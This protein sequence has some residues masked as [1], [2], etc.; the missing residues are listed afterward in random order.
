LAAAASL[1]LAGCA[2]GS[3]PAAGN[4]RLRLAVSSQP[5]SLNP[6]FNDTLTVVQELNRLYDDPL[7]TYDAD[8]RLIPR[9]AAR[10][11]SI[12]NGDIS[13]D[14]RTIVVRLRHD[15]KWQDG[16]PFTS[17]DVRFSWQAMMDPKNNVGSRDGIDRILTIETPDPFTAVVHMRAAYARAVPYSFPPL[18][19]EHALRGADLNTSPFNAAPIGTGPFRVVAWKRGDYIDL[20]ANDAYYLGRPK[21]RTIRVNDVPAA[22]TRVIMLK[23]GEI[24]LAEL[25]AEGYRQV[26]NAPNVKV[27][28]YPSRSTFEFFLNVT[29][30]NL[31][32]VRVRRAIA[33]ALD[34][35]AL[36]R[37]SSYDGYPDTLANGY[38]DPGS[39]AYDPGLAPVPYDP[40]Q[41]ARLL[42][43]AGWHLASDGFRWKDGRRLTLQLVTRS[44]ASGE[45][46]TNT[47]AQAMLHAAGI[48]AQLKA[49]SNELVF[50]PASA[51][52]VLATGTFDLFYAS[53]EN[54][55]DPD[56]SWILTCRRR[57][58][59]GYNESRY[60]NPALDR[61]EA[62][63]L[64]TFD[65]GRRKAYYRQIDRIVQDEMPIVFVAWPKIAY[66]MSVR[67][68]GFAFNGNAANWNAYQWSLEP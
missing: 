52:G 37:S 62:L 42:D 26:K 28:V 20:A 9:I 57:E 49:Y 66:G 44:G 18:I 64:S 54:S 61:L 33:Y 27:E 3:A 22:N 31:T 56:S 53:Y 60:C 14:G 13:P 47:R 1:C 11:P 8:G 58:P 7:W 35:A 17:A 32:D 5:R 23:T 29:R 12:A 46:A 24:D 15:V 4:G 38:N 34:R 2:A 41:A 19:P 39:F 67:L 68:R 43:A 65:P 16:V 50:A 10:V 48:D 36:G 51:G 55:F 30:P 6:I 40:A 63:G 45:E 21:L 25:N 59:A